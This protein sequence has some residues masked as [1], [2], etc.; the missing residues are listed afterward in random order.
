[1]TEP[2]LTLA[3]PNDIEPIVELLGAQFK[4]HNI[5]APD[6]STRSGAFGI[7]ENP[8]RGFI[9]T[10]REGPLLLGIGCV[11]FTWTLEWGGKSAWLDELYV[12][13]ER[14]SQGLGRL[15]LQ[16]C[17]AEAKAQGCAAIDLEVV[18][19]HERASHLYER[20]GFVTHP[21]TRWY[22]RL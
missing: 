8:D 4:E 22:L 11:A 20:E 1:M 17:I 13:P 21:R 5:P 15:L 2:H 18:H 3:T 16:G 12:L 10:L 7:L 14:R 19:G 9:L 6:A